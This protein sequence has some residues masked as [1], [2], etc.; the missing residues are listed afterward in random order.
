MSRQAQLRQKS[1]TRAGRTKLTCGWLVMG[2]GGP[3]WAARSSKGDHGSGRRDGLAALERASSPLSARMQ[4]IW[5]ASERS[6]CR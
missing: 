4:A 6:A 3:A 5:R 1:R 2:A